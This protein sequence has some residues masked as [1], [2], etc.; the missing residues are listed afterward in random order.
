MTG[1]KPREP[2]MKMQA[3]SPICKGCLLSRGPIGL[4]GQD[5][6]R[7]MV[8][9]N[10]FGP[11]AVAARDLEQ[12]RPRSNLNGDFWPLPIHSTANKTRPEHQST[13]PTA[14]I[15]AAA[16]TVGDGHDNLPK[17]WA[18]HQRSAVGVK[19]LGKTWVRVCLSLGLMAVLVFF[20]VDLPAA[21]RALA[22]ANWWYL[23]LLALW[24]TADRLLMAY[25]WRLL[26]ICRSMA[27]SHWQSIRSYYLASFA[28]SFL[29]VTL[30]ADAL[31]VG[32]LTGPGRS[33]EALAA[34]VVVER[35][36]GFVA[37]T[38]AALIGLALLLTLGDNLPRQVLWITVGVLLLGALAVLL[39]LSALAQRLAEALQSRTS[40][41]GKL[42][43][44]LGR[45]F[46]AYSAYRGHV[47]TLSAF[48]LLSI[49]E[50]A[51]PVG[52]A[53]L[54]ALAIG[55]DLPLVKAAAVVP[56][57][58]LLARAPVSLSGFGMV[59]G[60]YVA[61]FSLVGV[62]ATSAFLLGFL[63]NLASLA[64]ATPGALFYLSG[65]LNSREL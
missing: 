3:S 49:V 23:A 38:V 11:G 62:D 5:P 48:V 40:E 8:W 43:A 27:V 58:I 22:G 37:S 55:V 9:E 60:L 64:T 63:T 56:V 54:S 35:A 14:Y 46:S 59:E 20:M 61:F 1:H 17:L 52:A 36:L 13:R 12:A 47:G 45:F 53:W 24:L 65:G 51:A 7:T 30:G 15:P 33:S 31:R 57:A 19:W 41:R 21:G 25:K 16:L 18:I 32:A 28:G 10:R 34:S 50:Q 6:S 2:I 4:A 44:W 39:S 26:A 29:P 42:L